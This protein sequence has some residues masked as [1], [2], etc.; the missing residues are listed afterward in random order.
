MLFQIAILTK[1]ITGQQR[2]II[3][4]NKKSELSKQKILI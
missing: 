2:W 3:M 1:M 4:H